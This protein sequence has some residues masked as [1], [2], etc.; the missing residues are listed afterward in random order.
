MNQGAHAAIQQVSGGPEREAQE[1]R[2]R[3]TRLEDLWGSGD[4][5]FRV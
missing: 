4:L 1:R 3:G 2:R 5:G